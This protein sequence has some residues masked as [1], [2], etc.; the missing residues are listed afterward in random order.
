MDVP[1]IALITGAASGIGAACARTFARDGCSG[2]ALLDINGE[3]LEAVKASILESKPVTLERIELFTC[4]VTDEARVT[5]ILKQAAATFGRLDYV[6][7]AAGIG[8]KHVG[9]AAFVPTN[10]WRQVLSINLDGTFFVVRAAAQIMLEQEPIKSSIDGRPLQRGSIVNFSSILGAVGV[11]LSTAYTASKHAVLGLT[12]TASEDLAAKGVRINAICPGYTAT[13]MTM[14]DGLIRAAMD[15]R[16]TTMVPMG[17]MGQPQEIADGVVYLAG[18]RSSFVCGTGESSRSLETVLVYVLTV[19]DSAF[20]RWWLHKSMNVQVR[21]RDCPSSNSHQNQ[22]S[23]DIFSSL[24]THK[25]S[26]K[27]PISLVPA[28][29][30]QSKDMHGPTFTLNATGYE[31]SSGEDLKW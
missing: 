16:V 9:G 28:P 4:N 30:T 25:D 22:R 26:S 11:P 31:S 6:I 1:G 27:V 13:P 7:N 17:R 12:R 2:L 29:V 8:K 5:E 18:G 19:S 20:R 21:V 3:A 14:S 24:Y 10:E 23:K 15:E